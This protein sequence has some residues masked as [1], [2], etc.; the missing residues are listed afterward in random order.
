V[1]YI[2]GTDY[3]ASHSAPRTW[4]S[5]DAATTDVRAKRADGIGYVF[6]ADD[7]Y[8][9]ID[10]DGCRDPETGALDPWAQAIVNRFNTYV[11]PSPSG[12]GVHLIGR[13][14]KPGDR[15]RDGA[16]EC[17]DRAHYFTMGEDGTG[18]IRD[19]QNELTA[20]YHEVWPPQA[21]QP[22][23]SPPM[24]TLD[25]QE[26]IDRLRRQGDGGKASRLLAG[27]ASGFPSPS[28]ARGKLSMSIAF[29]SD[30][31]DQIARI[32]VSS[33]LF[34]D[35]E[36]DRERKR[37]ATLDATTAVANYTGARFDPAYRS[38]PTATITEAWNG[39]RPSDDD[40]AA[41][42]AEI[43]DAGQSRDEL[44]AQIRVATATIARERA[45]RVAAEARA[46]RLSY[47]RS[48]VMR[49]LRAP[50]LSAGEK[51][52]AFGTVLDLGA[53]IANG[54]APAPAGYR[55]PAAVVAEKTGQKVTTV[56][57]QLNALNERGIIK[58]VTVREETRRDHVD[59][60]T[61]EIVTAPG[62]RDVTYINVPDGDVGV[63]IDAAQAFRRSDDAPARGGKRTRGC[64]D[65]PT[66]DIVRSWQDSCGECGVVLDDG[67]SVRRPD[68]SPANFAP[69]DAGAV[70]TPPT[71]SSGANFEPVPPRGYHVYRHHIL[72]PEEP[73]EGSRSKFERDPC[74]D[75]GSPLPPGH[76]YR[77]A[78]CAPVAMPPP[79]GAGTYAAVAS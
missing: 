45:R 74:V 12:T 55:L 27:D 48:A 2:P 31:A 47:E 26:V 76:R 4:R 22:A 38:I 35:G 51:L 28:E 53:R 77:C 67:Q 13:G 79:V 30:D 62:L 9:G 57:R 17:Y 60:E 50:A 14:V 43:P 34:K 66:A 40:H 54:E 23:A 44:L 7:P 69:E 18:A 46:D 29:Y 58:K 10:L 49:I 25:D 32:L 39:T 52:T 71:D 21:S 73:A 56:R 37:K 36:C 19:C 68:A 75:C 64:P 61:G 42:A 33:G 59:L 70:A 72:E 65:H 1:P 8:F 78:A 11:E 24:L 63:L 6:A 5:H 20:W 3:G 15:C 41:A 16:I